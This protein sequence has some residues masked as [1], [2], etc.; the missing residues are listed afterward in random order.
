MSAAPDDFA[1]RFSTDALPERD[2]LPMLCD[3]YGPLVVRF[4]MEPAG[5]EPLHFEI[6]AR[7]LPDLTVAHLTTSPMHSQ[8]T[9]KLLADGD[10]RV[11]LT[12]SPSGSPFKG[13][14]VGRDFV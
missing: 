4:D 14:H 7:V 9:R 13:A 3:F 11:S 8:R 2:R 10:D 5:D 1:I 12:L 6:N